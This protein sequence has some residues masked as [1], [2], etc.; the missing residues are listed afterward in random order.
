MPIP[1]PDDYLGHLR[2]AVIA[3]DSGDRSGADSAIRELA[4]DLPVKVPRRQP[5]PLTVVAVLRRNH[6]TCRYCGGQVVPTPVLRAV[7]LVWPDDI[8]WNRNW[9]ADSTHPIHVTR[10]ASIDHVSPHAHGGRGDMANSRL[11]R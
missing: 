5:S 1:P 2:R 3:L 9:R 4:S 11:T 10:S 6:F 7:S 8:P